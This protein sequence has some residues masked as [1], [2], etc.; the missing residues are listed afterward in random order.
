M[1]DDAESRRAHFYRQFGGL[2]IALVGIAYFAQPLVRF[3]PPAMFA[4]GGCS[5]SAAAVAAYSFMVHQRKRE[6]W[7][8]LIFGVIGLIGLGISGEQALRDSQAADRSCREIQYRLLSP[9]ATELDAARFQAF[10]CR[11]RLGGGYNW[12]D[13]F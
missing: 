11:P 2:T 13:K 1:N 10:G 5:V 3:M 9:K 12:L 7:A 6:Q 4:L 8:V